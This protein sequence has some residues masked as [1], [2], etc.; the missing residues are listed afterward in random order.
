MKIISPYSGVTRRKPTIIRRLSAE[1]L[2]VCHVK[3]TRIQSDS[4]RK[5]RVR[6][7]MVDSL[8]VREA[9][10]PSVSDKTINNL[11]RRNGFTYSTVEHKSRNKMTIVAN[12]RFADITHYTPRTADELTIASSEHNVVNH[13]KNASVTQKH[14]F[15]WL[16]WVVLFYLKTLPSAQNVCLTL[17]SASIH[18][19]EELRQLNKSF[20]IELLLVPPNTTGM[21]QINDLVV[22]GTVKAKCRKKF[23]GNE[24]LT[25]LRYYRY[26]KAVIAV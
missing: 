2:V 15:T 21:L 23:T 6:Q 8:A 18:R 4:P 16:N 3:H 1:K 12:T 17:D 19:N 7:L 10:D 24:S 13:S 14:I 26:I 20:S 9:I 25:P 22:F 11:M 5:E